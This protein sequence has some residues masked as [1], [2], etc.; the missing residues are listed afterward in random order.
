MEH[1]QRQVNDNIAVFDLD[2]C[3]AN[4]LWRRDRIPPNPTTGLHYDFYHAG[5]GEDQVLVPGSV[6]LQ[7]H[8]DAGDFIAFATARPFKCAEM[9]TKWIAKNFG[10]QPN[11]DF[12]IL[13]RK[14][15]DDRGSVEVKREFVGYLRTYERD[16]GRKIIAAYDDRQD[17]VDLYLSEGIPGVYRLDETGLHSQVSQPAP[18]LSAASE[19]QRVSSGNGATSGFRVDGQPTT[20]D[21]I[22]EAGTGRRITSE[23]MGAALDAISRA[24]SPDEEQMDHDEGYGCD[25]VGVHIPPSLAADKLRAALDT[26]MNRQVTYG[27]NDIVYA[28]VMKKLFPGKVVLKSEADHRMFLMV[29]HA[30]GKLT[31]FTSSG[32]THADSAH[33]LI[34][35]AAFMELFADQHN[36]QVEQ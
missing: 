10:I 21:E 26:F 19:R 34:N 29:M 1:K 17:I 2:G 30:V 9:T 15:E 32:M 14:N 36:I 11:K 24:E 3:I 25:S 22:R 18:S 13:M 33:D 7:E 4:D 12:L 5:C 16:S 27:A 8:I 28:Q 20:L 31:R 6:R 23:D 35:Y